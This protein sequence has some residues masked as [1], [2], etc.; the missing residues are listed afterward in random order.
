MTSRKLIVGNWKMNGLAEEGLALAGA[1][2]AEAGDACD[3]GI[4]PPAI[5]LREVAEVLAG[6]T[7]LLG[8]QD[9]HGEVSGAHTGDISA[10]MLQDAGCRFVICGHSERRQDHAE[11]DDLIQSKALAAHGVGLMAI[12][13]VGETGAEHDAGDALGVIVR[14]LADSLPERITPGDTVI[15]YEP[16][17]AI[18]TGRTPSLAE[19]AD[20]HGNIRAWLEGRAGG[21]GAASDYRILYGGS[22]KPGNAREIL[23]LDDVGGA[24]VGGASLQAADF[25]AICAAC[26]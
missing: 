17:W 1:V 24:L 13:C 23:A 14:Q 5:L 25:L 3:I 21:V 16:V 4:A 9:C 8:G 11:S 15:A 2:A 20:M 22:V 26:R 6:G 18:G 12:I 10:A 19:I 7:V